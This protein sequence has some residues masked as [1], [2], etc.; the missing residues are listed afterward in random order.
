VDYTPVIQTVSFAAGQSTATVQIPVL[1]GDPSEGSRVVELDLAPAPG[2]PATSATFLVITHNT[3]TTPPKVIATRMLTRGR[4][5]TGFVITFSKDMAPG[6]V[7]DVSNYAIADPRSVRPVPGKEWTTANHQ[8]ALKS[9]TYDPLTHSVTLKTA[10]KVK[11]FPFF[12][13]LDTPLADAINV[14][15]QKTPA[16][17]AQLLPKLSPI[18]DTT[19]NPLDGTGDGTADGTLYA[20]AVSG[21]AGNRFLKIVSSLPGPEAMPPALASSPF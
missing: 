15:G 11:K 3:D 16:T 10:G 17:A 4:F 18:T 13:I 5:V 1:P 6:P 12:M 21:K 20:L 9:A 19:G 14:V 8:I 7:H 2:A